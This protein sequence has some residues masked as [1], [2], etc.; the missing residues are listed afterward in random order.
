MVLEEQQWAGLLLNTVIRWWVGLQLWNWLGLLWVPKLRQFGASGLKLWWKLC[1]LLG[2]FLKWD[3][4]SSSNIITEW[5]GVPDR[6]GTKA[7]WM[8]PSYLTQSFLGYNRSEGAHVLWMIQQSQLPYLQKFIL[9][10]KTDVFVLVRSGL[11]QKVEKKRTLWKH[12]V[13]RGKNAE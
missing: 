9:T 11:W 7:F 2:F 3:G 10:K 1:F 5:W 6:D 8:I 13:P 4:E 12:C